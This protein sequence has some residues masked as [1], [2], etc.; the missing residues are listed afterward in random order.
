MAKPRPRSEVDATL[1]NMGLT[2][3]SGTATGSRRV[4]RTDVSI[5]KNYLNHEEIEV[6]NLIVSAYLDFAELQ[7]RGRKPMAMRDWITKLDFST[8]AASSIGWSIVS[9][10][11]VYF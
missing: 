7:A 9:E 10:I 11:V 5:A 6:L 3:W 1:P 8:A 2:S 4:K